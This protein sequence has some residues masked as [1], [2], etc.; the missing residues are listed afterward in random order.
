MVPACRTLDAVSIFALT[1]GDAATVLAAAHGEDA[2]DAY[3]R[4][5]PPTATTLALPARFR[6]GVPR[7]EDLEFHGNA[8]GPALFAAGGGAAAAPW[9]ARRS[10]ST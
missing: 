4:A 2:A 8:E 7:A 10:R 3:S 5:L 6:F 1:A 9:A